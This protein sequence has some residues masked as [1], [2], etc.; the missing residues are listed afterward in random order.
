M[1]KF[2]KASSL[3]H[4]TRRRPE[5]ESKAD[6]EI[7]EVYQKYLTK[8]LDGSCTKEDFEHYSKELKRATN[9]FTESCINMYRGARRPE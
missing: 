2:I 6:R 3:D 8:I 9:N 5:L 1:A 7:S 4:V